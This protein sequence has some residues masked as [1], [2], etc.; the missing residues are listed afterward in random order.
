MVAYRT[1]GAWG[2][3]L[4]RNLT[5]A[6]VDGNFWELV[7]E[8]ADIAANA[9]AG[10][11]IA[12]ITQLGTL[13]TFHLSDSTT[14]QVTLPT[15]R[16]TWRG[17]WAAGTLYNVND[18]FRVSGVGVYVVK[19]Q[20]TAAAAPFVVTP[21]V[22]LMMPDLLEA[23]APV[24]NQ[25]AAFGLSQTLAGRYI[26]YNSAT[27]LNLDILADANMTVE[28]GAEFNFRQVGAGQVGFV[29]ATG[30]TLNGMEGFN[31]RTR[32]PGSVATLKKVAANEW[33]LFGSLEEIV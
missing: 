29:P 18:Y 22:E 6:E 1:A 14:R 28:I 23:A 24:V 27:D 20:H 3:G 19:T 33:D 7:Q 12:N 15:S 2:A 16:L 31:N 11:G 26:R 32:A 9:P 30:V 4:G 25:T 13:V 21:S 5:A 8:I 10:V 17:S